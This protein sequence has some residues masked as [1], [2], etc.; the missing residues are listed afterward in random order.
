MPPPPPPPPPPFLDQG[1]GRGFQAERGVIRDLQAYVNDV[2]Y[3]ARGGRGDGV[4]RDRVGLR[5]TIR[6]MINDITS[7]RFEMVVPGTHREARRPVSSRK[8]NRPARGSS[9][10]SN[11]DLFAILDSKGKSFLEV[12][13]SM[14]NRARADLTLEFENATEIPLLLDLEIAMQNS[15]IE[16]VKARMENRLRDVRIKANTSKWT[17]WKIDHGFDSRVGIQGGGLLGSVARMRLRFLSGRR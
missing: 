11:Q 7:R 12:S 3:R 6:L 9:S 14:L 16:T 2:A 4:Q 10:L 1:S 5:S 8:R 17:R 13:A 15:I